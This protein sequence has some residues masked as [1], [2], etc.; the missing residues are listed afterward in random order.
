MLIAGTVNK[1]YFGEQQTLPEEVL[2]KKKSIIRSV[3][4]VAGVKILSYTSICEITSIDFWD[5]LA[6]SVK[7]KTQSRGLNN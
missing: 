6:F 3:H 7:Y 2:T 1:H 4:L 5:P